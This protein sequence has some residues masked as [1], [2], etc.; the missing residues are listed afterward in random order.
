MAN[1]SDCVTCRNI[2]H[3]SSI[4]KSQVLIDQYFIYITIYQSFI[5][6]S[7]IHHIYLSIIP[8]IYSSYL[9]IHHNY[10]FLLSI[11]S[12]M[13]IGEKV[14]SNSGFGNATIGDAVMGLGLLTIAFYVIAFFSLLS[15]RISYTRL[16]HQGKN[17]LK[18]KPVV[19]NDTTTT[20]D[21]IH[22]VG[23]VDSSGVIT[24]DSYAL[25]SENDIGHA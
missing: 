8:I 10:L 6:L 19:S 12:S 11:Y 14:L 18:Y 5:Y 4:Y 24:K 25:V 9:S 1:H 7:T 3:F 22:G 17:Y 13:S 21:I 16:G 20:T 2:N 15:S 23:I